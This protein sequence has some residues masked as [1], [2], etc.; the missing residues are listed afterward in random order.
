[1]DRLK[2]IILVSLPTIEA[3]FN[4][5]FKAIPLVDLIDHDVNNTHNALGLIY[6]QQPD[7]IILE[8]D[9]PG[10]DPNSFTQLIRKEFP[11]TQVI[12][13]AEVASVESVRLAMRAGA[14]DFISYKNL[15][16]EEL[17]KTL[18]HARQLI[19]EERGTQIS[20]VKISESI[21]QKPGTPLSEKQTRVIAI[22]SP[23]GGAGVSTITANLAWSLSSRNFK[24]LVVDGDFLYGDMG[25][26]LNQQSN[27]SIIDLVRFSGE[28][29][30][31][32]I[33]NI[34]NHGKVDLLAA[35][36]NVDKFVE[37]NGPDF[38]KILK[39]LSHD[40]YDYLLI[41]TCSHLSDPIIFAL[42]F[43]ETVVVVGTQEISSLRATRLFLDLMEM[44][45][46]ARE[47]FVV[48]INRFEKDSIL[49]LSKYQEFLK[50]NI[51]Q[52]IPYDFDT[53]LLANNL[54]IPFV[55]DHKNKPVA[56]AID[57]LANTLVKG[58]RFNDPRSVTKVLNNIKS[59]LSKK[60][61]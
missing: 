8:N 53:V 44:L 6:A 50:I 19:D 16:V 45:L 61:P 24:V 46:I 38:G 3:T 54:G 7:I 13:I 10:I 5:L 60:K 21:I 32:V 58:E 56:R 1:M 39:K 20:E 42:E 25:V 26:L 15:T 17:S 43:A 22:Y 40:N 11:S 48:V 27:H 37:I 4:E 28:L 35:P 52:T 31:D 14:C 23:K 57:Y 36:P 29:E 55:E 41:N 51:S 9:F 47:K 12:I 2:V 30:E 33:Q 49:T 59:K 18:E 34:I